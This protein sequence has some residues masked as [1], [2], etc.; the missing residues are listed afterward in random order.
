MKALT[1]KRNPL[2][3]SNAGKSLVLLVTLQYMKGFTLDRSLTY[4]SNAGKPSFE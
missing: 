4:G 3:A 2:F 1:L